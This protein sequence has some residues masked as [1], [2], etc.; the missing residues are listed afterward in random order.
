[1]VSRFVFITLQDRKFFR[2]KLVFDESP[3]GKKEGID[4]GRPVDEVI[5]GA[6]KMKKTFLTHPP[7]PPPS[8]LINSFG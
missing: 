8:L 7:P 5:T 6:V 1:M 3:E 2:N 4:V